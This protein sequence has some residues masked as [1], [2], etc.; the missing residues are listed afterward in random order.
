M[1]PGLP[2]IR[3]LSF[4]D[5]DQAVC[6][7]AAA[8]LKYLENSKRSIDPMTQKTYEYYKPIKRS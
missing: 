1:I 7:C 3:N 2:E 4:T 5:I 8:T 6:Q